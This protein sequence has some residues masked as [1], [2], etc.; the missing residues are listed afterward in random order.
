MRKIKRKQLFPPRKRFWLSCLGFLPL[1]I[2][3]AMPISASNSADNSV[4]NNASNKPDYTER[5]RQHA[6]QTLLE[7]ARTQ[8][9]VNFEYEIDAWT[10]ENAEEQLSCGGA[11]NVEP[12]R[13]EGRL[14]G[15]VPYVVSCNEPAWQ[16][17]ARAEV[18]VTVPVVTARRNISKGEVLDNGNIVLENRDLARI[19]GDFV[20]DRRLVTGKRAKRALRSGRVISL[21]QVTA[22]LL[23]ERGSHVVIRVVAEGITASMT[24]E[25]LQDGVEG[26]GILVRNHSSGKVITA[27]VAEKG[28]VETRF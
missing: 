4:D 25:A 27:W 22:P 13:P 12:A 21:G 16:I 18:S 5:V 24:G 14:W 9:W 1:G 23:V 6:E 28:I 20:T 19:F 2:F 8:G 7:H 17:R 26:E 3:V 10:P 11:V 15:R